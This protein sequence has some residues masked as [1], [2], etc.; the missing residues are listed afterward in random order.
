MRPSLGCK[1][2]CIKE[3]LKSEFITLK[4][5]TIE[6]QVEYLN[7]TIWC[8]IISNFRVGG[9]LRNNLKSSSG[10]VNGSDECCVERPDINLDNVDLLARKWKM[11]EKLDT[12]RLENAVIEVLK[13]MDDSSEHGNNSALEKS[14]GNL[15]IYGEMVSLSRNTTDCL[16]RIS[17]L[18]CIL[19]R[20]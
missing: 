11:E 7:D 15:D 6:H 17:Y 4:N 1:E 16:G 19:N 10:D 8:E 18:A 13:I 2:T 12:T 14:L 20:T 9:D 3:C 5:I